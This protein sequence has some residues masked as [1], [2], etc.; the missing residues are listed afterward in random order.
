LWYDRPANDWVEALPIGNGH[1]GAMVFGGTVCERIQFNED[2]LFT[3]KPHNY[4]HAG[5]HKHLPKLRQLLW[6]GKQDEAHRLAMREFMSTSTRN[7]ARRVR[8][9]K[10]QPFGDLFLEF[11]HH[12]A[13]ADYHRQLDIDRAVVTVEYI[14]GE[15][16]YRRELFASYPDDAI[17]VRLT[18]DRSGHVGFVARLVSSHAGA[19]VK[20]VANQL[21]MQGRVEDGE[22]RFEARLIVHVDGS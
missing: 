15:Q 16:R 18:S 5:A 2:T 12:Q 8:Q 7:D 1:F 22:T 14:V 4:A 13:A 17:V 6:D 19:A 9:E 3:G 11:P 20:A 10:Y 21:V